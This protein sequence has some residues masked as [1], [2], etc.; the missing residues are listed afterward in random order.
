MLSHARLHSSSLRQN[1]QL[2]FSPGRRRS[3]LPPN[4][5]NL[6]RSFEND[7]TGMMPPTLCAATAAKPMDAIHPHEL[8]GNDLGGDYDHH[9]VL[10]LL[11]PFS[12]VHLTLYLIVS[13]AF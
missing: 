3:A 9:P 8:A 5:P 1:P 13:P 7:S 4:L 6:D 10:H 2:F 11:E 12:C